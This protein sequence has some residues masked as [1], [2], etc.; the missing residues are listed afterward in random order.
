[1]TGLLRYVD[2][3]TFRVPDLESGIA[4]YQ[5]V[6]GHQVLWRD[7]PRG[8]V[9]LGTPE[10]ATEV[11]LT[12]QF[13]YEPN[14]KVDSADGAGQVF[15]AHG[16]RVLAGPDEIPIGRVVA[17][18]DPFGNGLVLLDNTAGTYQTDAQGNVTGVAAKTRS[19]P[20]PRML[21]SPSGVP[22]VYVIVRRADQVLL[23]L[24]SGTGY[25]DG[26]W[27]PPSGKVEDAETYR[28]AAARE[29]REETGISVGPGELRF[30]HVIERL[31]ISG[32]RWVGLFFEVDAATASPVNV[33]AD[34]HEAL[35]FFPVSHLP[36]N[37]VDYVRYV[38][39]AVATS[40]HLSEW[41]Y[42]EAE[43]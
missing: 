29:L 24:R 38:L 6:L 11:V 9:G 12:T 27:G 20:E 13:G 30:I 32:S 3:V 2:A 37:T 1:M 8:Q 28:E 23:L 26:Q 40:R 19:I 22:D 39:Q 16:G 35:A 43:E 7:E 25:K 18:E 36:D 5:G 42:D 17:V 34:K 21:P 4:F 33:E 31:P 14:W 10:S 15:A 41:K